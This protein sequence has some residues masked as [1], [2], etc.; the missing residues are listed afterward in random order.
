MSALNIAKSVMSSRWVFPVSNDEKIQRVMADFKL[1]EIVARILV[2]RGVEHEKIESYLNPKLARDFPD[3]FCLKGMEELAECVS[4]H[5]IKGT[6]IAAFCDF[7]VDGSTSAAILKKFYEPD[8]IFDASEAAK[9]KAL[10]K[11]I[12]AKQIDAAVKWAR[13]RSS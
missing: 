7:D 12:S 4:E 11:K 8:K 9:F 10:G 5:V 6:R 13:S 2:T 1:P 3:P